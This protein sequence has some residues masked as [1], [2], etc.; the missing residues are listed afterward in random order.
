M[1][2]NKEKVTFEEKI[3]EEV[4]KRTDIVAVAD[5]LICLIEKQYQERKAI[6]ECRK[7]RKD[8]MITEIQ[9]AVKERDVNKLDKLLERLG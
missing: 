1:G 6:A 7:G 4:Q 5:T 8:E 2:H 9:K 3:M